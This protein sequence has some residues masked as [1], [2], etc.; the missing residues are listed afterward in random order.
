MFAVVAHEPETGTA[1]P[2]S[3]GTTVP[4]PVAASSATALVTVQSMRALLPALFAVAL[5][6][7]GCGD[8]SDGTDVATDG[9]STTTP[10]DGTTTST[11]AAGGGDPGDLPG[12]PI[13]LFPFEGAQLAVVGVAADDVLNVRS[14]PGTGFDVVVELPPLA[15][16][17]V[18]TGNNRSLDE[19][20][21]WAE[22]EAE[23][24]TGWANT[25]FLL[26]PGPVTDITTELFPTP[27]DRIGAETMLELG[28]AVADLRA[29]EEPPS[30]IVVVD[31]PTV[32]D[33]GE[34]T[35]DVIGLGDDAVGG[36]RLAVF[37]EP[38]PSGE[39]FVVRT[40]EATTLCLRGVTEGLCT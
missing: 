13:D 9:T 30:D 1:N 6:V 11:T 37:A 2:S 40:V 22:V 4:S 27:A 38:D 14:G 18:A 36:E 15:A 20:G 17:V 24:E 16:G 5:L 34:I 21:I 35:V 10:D 23:G 3:T 19:Q 8:D 32:G 26:Q 7:A 31:G 33:L 39:G 29:S 28:R 12:E 25:A